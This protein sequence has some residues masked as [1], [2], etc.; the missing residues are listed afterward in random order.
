M[1]PIVAAAVCLPPWPRATS[2][3]RVN[4][5]ETWSI[6]FRAVDSPA[7]T[8][9]RFG[10]AGRSRSGLLIILFGQDFRPISTRVGSGEHIDGSSLL[11][12]QEDRDDAR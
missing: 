1:F 8:H 6:L 4:P 10:R 9:S 2:P 7:K 5:S 3:P 11:S 12:G